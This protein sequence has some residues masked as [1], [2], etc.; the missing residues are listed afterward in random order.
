M[1]WSP[2]EDTPDTHLAKAGV[3]S[4]GGLFLIGAALLG[5]L[6]FNTSVLV[7]TFLPKL[8]SGTPLPLDFFEYVLQ[9]SW[10]AICIGL[11]ALLGFVDDWSKARGRGGLKSHEKLAGQIVLATSFV[12]VAYLMKHPWDPTYAVTAEHT[13]LFA[14]SLFTPESDLPLPLL[15]LIVIALGAVIVGT[16]NA[17]NLTD[18]IDGLAA[19][20]AI[21]CGLAFVWIGR[22]PWDSTSDHYEVAWIWAALAGACL[23]FLAYNRHPARVFMGDTGS[24]AQGAALGAAALL[25]GSVFLLPFVGFIFFAE[26]LSVIVQVAYF[27]YSKKKYGEGRRLFRRAPLHHHYELAGW[28][29]WR[30]VA[31]FWAVNSITTAIGL[32]LWDAGYLPKFP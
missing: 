12:L 3:P 19:G 21:Q 1:R 18:G 24:L 5:Y 26:T 29:E 2:R 31:T 30:V 32:F 22:I 10:I 17:V 4:M 13:W 8:P 11:H 25:T 28:S 20:L 6:A 7:L 27:K 14:E 15:A 16:S 9:T 23:G